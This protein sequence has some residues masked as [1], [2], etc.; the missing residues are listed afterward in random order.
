MHYM[1]SKSFKIRLSAIGIFLII[2]YIALGVQLVRIQLFDYEKYSRMAEAQHNKRIELTAHRGPILDCKGRKLA[3]SLILCSVFANPTEVQEKPRTAHLLAKTLRLDVSRVLKLLEKEKKF[4]WIKRKIT[5]DEASAIEKLNL[6]GIGCREE[7]DRFYPNGTLCSQVVGF[8]DIDG[9]GLEG[10]E[11]AFD[12]ILSGES[13]YRLLRRDALQ[14]HLSTLEGKTQTPRH[15][16]GIMLTIDAVIQTIVEDALRKA[17][18]TYRPISAIA[19][20]MVPSTGDILAMANL[21]SYDPN[22]FWRYS[23]DEW[24]SRA[25]TDCYEP[26]SLLK[27]VV[28]SGA[29][30]YGL[31]TPEDVFFCHNGVYTIGKR[32]LHDVHE[33]GRLT[34]AEILIKSSNIGMAKLGMLMGQE[35]LYHHLRKF[36]FGEKTNVE[37][38]GEI[39]GTVRPLRAWS[40]YS[41][42]SIPMGHEI[43]VTPLQI[44]TAFCA[45]ANGGELLRPRIVRAITESNG[46]TIKREFTTPTKIRRVISSTVA[47]DTMTPILSRVVKD[48]TGKKVDMPEYEVAGKTGTA[49]KLLPGGRGYTASKY[50]SSFIG[51]APANHPEICVLVILD[52]PRSGAYYGGTVAAPAVREII[53]KSLDYMGVKPQGVLPPTS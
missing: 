43:A 27:P 53:R 30:E 33:Y 42:T 18:E 13:G 20:A 51:Y 47:N 16:D 19:I 24:R 6:Q 4:V 34:L 14:R 46:K 10:I 45:I 32:T 21:P 39:S 48:G 29:L 9:K 41:V 44:L 25:V 26:G 3:A 8:V 49:Q 7:T 17:C 2:A 40:Y 37:L 15:G 28:A 36:G 12:N 38:P 31:A 52:E 5:E 11:L 35:K 22:F 1:F 50:I 23:P